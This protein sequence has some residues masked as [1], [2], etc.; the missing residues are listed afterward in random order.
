MTRKMVK[1]KII[2]ID[3]SKCDGCGLCIPACPEAAIQ[4]IDGKARL[5]D[6]RYCDGLGKCIGQ[7][8][9]G[10]ITLEEKETVEFDEE[11]VKLHIQQKLSKPELKKV[12][13]EFHD[14]SLSQW[15]I[16]L[17][18]VNPQA[19]FFKESDLLVTA[20]C[21]PFAYPNFHKDFLKGKVVVTGCPKF[22]NVPFY[23]EKLKSIFTESNIKSVEVVYMEVPCCFGLPYLVEETLKNL[24]LKLQLKHVMIGI[25]GEILEKYSKTI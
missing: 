5:V 8:P 10:A 7:C 9:K 15:P 19:R 13:E 17:E 1:R 21:V 23:R 24:G 14:V 12:C 25:G 4:I 11:A 18:L 16:K 20:D 6:E 22:G 2:K 3:E